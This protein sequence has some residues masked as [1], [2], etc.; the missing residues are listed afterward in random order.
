MLTHG[1][2]IEMMRIIG[3]HLEPPYSAPVFSFDNKKLLIFTDWEELADWLHET[4]D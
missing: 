1:D 3:Y 4:Y 2:L